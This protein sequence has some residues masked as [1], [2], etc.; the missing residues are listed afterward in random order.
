MFEL[1]TIV[2][3]KLQQYSD[4]ELWGNLVKPLDTYLSR[5]D[6]MIRILRYPPLTGSEPTQA[7]RA[8]PHEDINFITLLP[9]A[10]QS[11]LE[12]KPKNSGWKAVEAPKGS[13][14]VNV[15]DMLQ[16]LTGYKLPSTTHRVINPEGHRRQ[17]ERIT[18]PMFCHPEPSLRLSDKYTAGEYLRERLNEINV[19][20]MRVD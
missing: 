14:I 2:L 9:A 4:E 16:E 20:Q 19:R 12:I 15:G 10:T 1:A 8:A 13:V 18:A 6:T 7:M 17:E 3:I 11:G 5:Q